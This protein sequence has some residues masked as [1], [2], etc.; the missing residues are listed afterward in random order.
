MFTCKNIPHQISLLQGDPPCGRA[1]WDYIK[2]QSIGQ[3]REK[4]VRARDGYPFELG[5]G[6]NPIILHAKNFEV[7]GLQTAICLNS[8]KKSVPDR[9]GDYCL[10]L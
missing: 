5:G 10:K 1:E 2:S 6:L 3:L 9:N 4:N 7:L 8:K